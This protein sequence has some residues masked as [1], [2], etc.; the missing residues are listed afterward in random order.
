MPSG[1]AVALGT[2]IGLFGTI[3]LF[4]T[5]LPEKKKDSLKGFFRVVHNFFN[6]KSLWIEKILK[7]FYVLNTLCCIGIGF[8]LLFSKTTSL[9]GASQ[10]T[11]FSGLLLMIFGPIFCRIMYEAAI[12]FILQVKNVMEINTKLGGGTSNTISFTKDT[13][14]DVDDILKKI[15][16]QRAEK[17]AAE[18]AKKAEEAVQSAAVKAEEA[19]KE[20]EKAAAEAADKAEEVVKEAEKVVEEAAAEVKDAVD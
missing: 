15:E 13:D 4:F 16:A 19:V 11:F 9:F 7:F 10:S 3:A 8:F 6:I 5:I 1:V 17:E 14:M 20:A 2:V 12:L 18:A